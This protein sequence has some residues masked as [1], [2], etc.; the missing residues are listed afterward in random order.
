MGKILIV[1]DEEHF[2]HTMAEALVRRGHSALEACNTSDAFQLAIQ[3]EPELIISDICMAQGD[4][5]SFLKTV[6]SNPRTA[7][8]PFVVMTGQPDFEGLVFGAENAADAYLPKPFSI[9]TLINTVENRLDRE[10]LIRKGATEIKE[11]L[12][13]ILEASPDMIGIIEPKSLNF[14]FLNR[15]GRKLLGLADSVEI[16]SKKLANFY[17]EKYARLIVESAIPSALKEGIW[18]GEVSLLTDF[19]RTVPGKQYL[20]AHH[21]TEGEISYLSTIFHDLS[22]TKEAEAALRS[23]EKR[24]RSLINSLPDA[25][26]MHDQSGK[27]IFY[28]TQTQKMF[29][30][31]AGELMERPVEGLFASSAET[32]PSHPLE[33][34]QLVHSCVRKNGERFPADRTT[35]SFNFNGEQIQLSIVR[36]LSERDKLER[37][38][39]VMEIQLRQALKLES[40]GQLAAGIAHEINTPTQYIGDNARFLK[41]AFESLGKIFPKFHELLSLAKEKEL[42]PELT[43][44]VEKEIVSAD[45]EYLV[46][47]IPRAIQQSLEGVDRVTRL[48]RA[49]KDFSHPGVS[50][51]TAVDINH[52]I[53]STVTVARNEWKYVAEMDLQLDRSLPPVACLPAE[54]NQVILNLIINAAHAIADVVGDGSAKKGTITVSTSRIGDRI[55]IKVCDTGTGIPE[56][57]RARMYEPFFTTKEVGRGTGQG[58]AIARSVVVDKHGG[59]IDFET[60]MGKGTCF[61]VSLPLN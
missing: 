17:P 25:V 35:N 20:Q 39:Q 44:A 9:H 53:E 1:D 8:I 14:I 45:L 19:E 60:E 2:R 41:D 36:D 49:M 23:S 28:N 47:E 33:K 59:S 56:K 11:Q 57:V 4:G 34:N 15:S 30:Y 43:T 42:S 50:E 6:R 31:E 3:H 22:E 38:R 7:S 54:L 27:I 10:K 52:S 46:A 40:I 26:L 29:G 5:L 21:N 61:I 12:H 37:E 13:R 51:K 58:L 18:I 55:Q 16:S 48:V 24:F 32:A